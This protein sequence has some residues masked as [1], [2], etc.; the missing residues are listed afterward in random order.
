V[1]SG[2][3]IDEKSVHDVATTP[4]TTVQDRDDTP[5]QTPPR[6]LARLW[7]HR[8]S[9]F[10]VARNCV[11]SFSASRSV[12]TVPARST[13]SPVTGSMPTYTRTW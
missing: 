13:R 11:S 7:R 10:G 2:P 3:N 4:G 5:P 12:A 1:K 6:P 8:W 9:A